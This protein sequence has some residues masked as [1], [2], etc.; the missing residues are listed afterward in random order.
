MSR[1]TVAS[2]NKTPKESNKAEMGNILVDLL[3]LEVISDSSSIDHRQQNLLPVKQQSQ[4]TLEVDERQQH[5]VPAKFRRLWQYKS[6]DSSQQVN[7]LAQTSVDMPEQ[8]R[9]ETSPFLCLILYVQVHNVGIHYI[10]IPGVHIDTDYEIMLSCLINFTTY[11]QILGTHHIYV[12]CINISANY[13]LLALLLRDH[14]VLRIVDG[15]GK[16]RAINGNDCHCQRAPFPVVYGPFPHCGY[17][18][19]ITSLMK[20]NMKPVIAMLW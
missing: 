17:G 3:H 15:N 12:L 13:V 11:L 19:C 9:T 20:L 10:Y 4:S 16:F 5:S 2:S 18:T 1:R 7:K 6:V 8:N 14:T